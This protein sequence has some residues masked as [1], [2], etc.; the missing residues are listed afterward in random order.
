[1]A[2]MKMTV[3]AKKLKIAL[4]HSVLLLLSLFLW[5]LASSGDGMGLR[6]ACTAASLIA[7][8]SFGIQVYFEGGLTASF[9]FI[10]IAFILFQF[11]IPF[12]YGLKPG[13]STSYIFRN[14]EDKEV[15]SAVFYSLCCIQLFGLGAVFADRRDKPGAYLKKGYLQK[16]I[17]QKAAVFLAA[18]S[19]IVAFPYAAFNMY[20]TLRHGYASQGAKEI[21]FTSGLTN[22]AGAV[23]VPSMILAMVYAQDKRR[24]IASSAVLGAY[25]MIYTV[26]GMRSTGVILLLVILFYL[27]TRKARPDAKV[28]WKAKAGIICMLFLLMV[29]SVVIA[30]ARSG[31]GIGKMTVF[32]FVEDAVEE[33]G[34]S[35]TSIC[36]TQKYIPD[37]TPFKLGRSYLNSF[38]ALIPASL[39]FTGTVG[40]ILGT[41]P[42][43]WLGRY[44]DAAGYTFGFG[45]SVIAES[46]YNFGNFGAIAIFIQGYVIKWVMSFKFIND[47]KFS[48]YLN[49]IFMYALL[50][51]PRRQFYT[52]VKALE[53]NVILIVMLLFLYRLL[54]VN[55]KYMAWGGERYGKT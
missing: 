36:F 23:F 51:Y 11:G 54:K 43:K 33:L 3:S 7:I 12:L 31:Y 30:Y 27:Y 35:F 18:V 16:E 41:M 14:F 29:L 44:T 45:Y 2:G 52:L 50:T 28:G 1:M 19:G 34:F 17:V 37:D 49:L 13:Y 48:G 5:L 20:A 26:A 21:L 47:Q 38:I 32:S 4:I 25:A 46:F 6:L 24:L 9:T 55:W 39:D 15:V 22:A 53:Y 42:E 10:Y 8:A 40:E